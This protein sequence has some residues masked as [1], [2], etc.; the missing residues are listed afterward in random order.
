MAADGAVSPDEERR[1]QCRLL[2]DLMGAVPF[3]PVA[4][5]PP[6]LAW[7]G[8]TVRRLA[9][10]IYALR[11]FDRVAVLGDALEESG[12]HDQDILR[13]CR[14]QGAVHVRGCWVVDAV[15]GKTRA[16]GPASPC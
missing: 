5:A 10:D 6:W 9:E 2:R 4:V 14:E 16:G 11:A 12:C 13:H 3:G 15:L 7:N 1:Y 8:G